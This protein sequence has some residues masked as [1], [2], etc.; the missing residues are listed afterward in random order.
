ME[1]GGAYGV[2]SARPY[3]GTGNRLA[4]LRHVWDGSGKPCSDVEEI[5]DVV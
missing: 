1:V 5:F 4:D 3:Y 2:L